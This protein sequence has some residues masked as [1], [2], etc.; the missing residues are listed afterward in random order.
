MA[1]KNLFAIVTLIACLLIF[2]QAEWILLH[3]LSSYGNSTTTV[4]VA[5]VFGIAAAVILIVAV[6]NRRKSFALVW[7]AI[8]W[9][10][11]N[12]I[13]AITYGWD[14][15]GTL[16]GGGILTVIVFALFVVA[17]I[18]YEDLDPAKR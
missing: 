3:S 14:T 5:N 17:I 4:G 18:R 13:I 10:V 12:C 9:F 16:V 15:A 2:A 6:F 1:Q 7:S 8:A 11:M